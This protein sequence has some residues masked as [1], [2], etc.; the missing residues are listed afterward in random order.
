VGA[1]ARRKGIAVARQAVERAREGGI[2]ASLLTVGCPPRSTATEI[3][4]GWV[5]EPRKWQILSA[6]DAF[7]LPT[8]Y[9]AYSLAV[10]E[11]AS[12]GLPIVTTPQSGVDEGTSGEDYVLCEPSDVGAFAQA[13]IRLYRDPAWAAQLGA[14]G[15]S[16]IAAWTYECQA[17]SWETALRQAIADRRPG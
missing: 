13:L 5:A 17:A 7:L 15:R 6:S 14:R 12:V 4:F 8:R 16:A 9:E 10:R 3:G 2:P 1:D 11:A